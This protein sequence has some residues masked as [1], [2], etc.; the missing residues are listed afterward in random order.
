MLTHRAKYALKALIH[1]ARHAD[2][3]LVQ[4]GTMAKAE[5]IPLKYLEII[6]TQLRNH[7]IIASKVG[8]GGGHRLM[9]P[10]AE[11][12]LLTVVRIIDGPVAPLPC[13]SQT[14][15]RRCDDCPDEGA[16]GL[17][18]IMGAAHEG[19]LAILSKTTVAMALVADPTRPPAP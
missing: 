10:P 17:R 3:G 1:L 6:L 18:R 16:C 4:A 5:Q 9:K 14:A 7:G 19:Q 12:D 8:K 15:Y 11:I 2:H 13:L